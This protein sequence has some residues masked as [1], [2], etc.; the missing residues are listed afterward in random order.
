MKP[1][2]AEMKDRARDGRM[3]IGEAYDLCLEVER[4]AEEIKELRKA[5]QGL[6]STYW[7]ER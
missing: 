1:N 4:Q 2:I 6:E 7:D 5:L 3:T